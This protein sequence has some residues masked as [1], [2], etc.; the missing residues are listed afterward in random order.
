MV[1]LPGS[2][3]L[4]SRLSTLD[5]KDIG[6]IIQIAQERWEE[7]QISKRLQ[8]TNDAEQI[9]LAVGIAN[10][11]ELEKVVSSQIPVIHIRPECQSLQAEQKRMIRHRKYSVG[12]LF[13]ASSTIWGL[14]A[15]FVQY[16]VTRLFQK[17]QEAVELHPLEGSKVIVTIPNLVVAS[18]CLAVTVGLGWLTKCVL[19][20]KRHAYEYH[21]SHGE[22]ILLRNDVLESVSGYCIKT[23]IPYCLIGLSV[24]KCK[25]MKNV[26][27]NYPEL[28]ICETHCFT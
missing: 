14:F 2:C 13:V 26:C 5:P 1:N 21:E 19:K 4:S 7:K 17:G 23:I 16:H 20:M 8:K 18:S 11:R 10:P 28:Y 25:S 15:Y 3:I 27:G 12:A 9:I 6:R 22:F 24:Y